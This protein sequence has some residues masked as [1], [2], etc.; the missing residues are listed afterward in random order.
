MIVQAAKSS[1]VFPDW[2][3]GP[4]RSQ[5][6]SGRLVIA[7][8]TQNCFGNC[9]WADDLARRAQ[10]ETMQGSAESL[11]DRDDSG[12]MASDRARQKDAARYLFRFNL[13][14]VFRLR[15][16]ASTGSAFSRK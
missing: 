3:P 13:S 1:T 5:F 10:A 4:A 12:Q 14:S 9:A 11:T 7:S 8:R 16:S 15:N 6:A 2:I